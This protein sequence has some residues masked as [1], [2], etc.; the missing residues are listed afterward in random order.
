[1]KKNL[2]LITLDALSIQYSSDPEIFHNL[3]LKLKREG[4]CEL[5][6]GII[7]KSAL[8]KNPAFFNKAEIYFRN[9]LFGHI[10]FFQS[11]RMRFE[12]PDTVI[13]KIENC[14]LYQSK[15]AVRINRVVAK[16]RLSFLKYHYVEIAIDGVGLVKIQDRY[17][18]SKHYKRV[19]KIKGN[20]PW[21]SD[22]VKRH[23]G[24]ILGS[25][26]SRKRIS[27]Y[28]KS[29]EIVNS[30]KEYISR[31]WKVNGLD[32][33]QNI[34]RCELKLKG[35][36]IELLSADPKD[37]E[38]PNH[39]A[40]VFKNLAHKYLEFRSIKNPKRKKSVIDWSYFGEMSHN[41]KLRTTKKA[42]PLL[43]NKNT[44]R[45]LFESYS[46]NQIEFYLMTLAHLSIE[47]GLGDFVRQ[48]LPRWIRENRL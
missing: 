14:A 19:Q 40:F 32:I 25:T 5:G 1:M 47:H 31:W 27:L 15:L 38:N 8:P 23:I 44:I 21:F 39:L 29:D 34:D 17:M 33:K 20:L 6:H 24:N 43:R 3:H 7:I 37:L 13:L 10:L 48:K 11:Q 4:K 36:A 18:T 16:L 45:C 30:G 35:G 22:T 9:Q 41:K 26:R 12:N 28:A 2:Y 46:V 42:I